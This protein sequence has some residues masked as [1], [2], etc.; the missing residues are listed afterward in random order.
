MGSLEGANAGNRDVFL[1]KLDTNGNE[2]WTK[3]WGTS[4]NDY[5]ISVA[6]DSSDNIYLTGYTFGS[7]FDVS[8]GGT[9]IFLTKLDTNG[10]EIWSEQWGTSENDYGNSVAVDSSDNIFV[11]GY[12]Y[13]SLDGNTNAGNYDAFLTRWESDGTKEWTEQWG[14]SSGDSAKSVVVDNSDNIYLTGHTYG[15]FPGHAH[16][17]GKDVFLTKWDK[18][19]SSWTKAW[20]EQWGTSEDDYGNSVAADSSDNIFVAGHTLGS[21]YDTSAGDR[22]IFLTKRDKTGVEIWKEQWGT[23]ENDFAH[24]VAVDSSDNIYVAG[25]TYGSLDGNTNAGESDIYITKWNSDE[26]KA[27]T[28]QWGTIEND[29]GY[30]VAV[31]NSDSVFGAGYTFGVFDGNTNAGGYDLFLTKWDL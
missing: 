14:T 16:A 24:S 20:T 22:D 21:L 1:T 27:W 29:Y 25:Y 2:I 4:E 9:D 5:G 12:T 28:K 11:A 6:V 18:G 19:G 31:D 8:K 30:L 26:T 15:S 17:G 13:G 7:L 23:S 3:Q 10:N